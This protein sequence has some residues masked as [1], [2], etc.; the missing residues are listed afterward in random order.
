MGLEPL[1]Y[2]PDHIHER[3]GPLFILGNRIYLNDSFQPGRPGHPLVPTV[4]GW[5]L[6]PVCLSLEASDLLTDL[7]RPGEHIKNPM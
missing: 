3:K 2:F 7:P 6:N 1:V 5:D 4:A